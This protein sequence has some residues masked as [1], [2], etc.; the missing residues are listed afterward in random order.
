MSLECSR[1][2][3][4]QNEE[5]PDRGSSFLIENLLRSSHECKSIEHETK[6]S[7]DSNDLDS[8]DK[9]GETETRSRKHRT[10]FTDVQLHTL[11]QAFEITK[12]LSLA[13]R[14]RM[15]HMLDMT[16]VQVKTWF[17]NRRMKYKRQHSERHLRQAT[18][19]AWRN[20]NFYRRLNSSPFAAEHAYRIYAHQPT[21]SSPHH[22][23]KV[24]LGARRSIYEQPWWRTSTQQPHSSAIPADSR[25]TLHYY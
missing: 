23:Y 3:I 7:V 9:I 6:T 10:T 13:E 19:T 24:N 5:K 22:P 18:P 15:A 20:D 1:S 12:Y 17:Q 14:Q 2:R 21:I 16:D 25:T 11:E 4:S 8:S